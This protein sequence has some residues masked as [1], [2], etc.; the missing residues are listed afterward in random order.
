[1]GTGSQNFKILNLVK[2]AVFRIFFAPQGRQYIRIPI[3]VK[4]GVEEHVTGKLYS[5]LHGVPNFTPSVKARGYEV[6]WLWLYPADLTTTR[7]CLR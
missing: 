6:A 2:F 1:M 7:Q 3:R 5:A 4:F